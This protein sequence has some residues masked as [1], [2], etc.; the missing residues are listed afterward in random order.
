MGI[1]M[2]RFVNT[3]PGENQLKDNEYIS[4]MLHPNAVKKVLIAGNSI[5]R[6]NP[7]PDIGWYGDWGMAAS[8]A[9]KDYV[10]ILRRELTE[11]FGAVSMCV[12][13]AAEWEV[14][15]C[16][17][18]EEKLTE[19]Y[20]PALEFGADLIIIRLGENVNMEKTNVTE[21]TESLQKLAAFLSGNRENVQVIMTGLFWN[22]PVPEE[23]VKSA[24]AEKS[25]H[26][27]PIFDLGM[28]VKMTASG[29]FEHSGVAG[30]PGDLGMEHIAGRVMQTI[31]QIYRKG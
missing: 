6:H 11:Y 31:K 16:Q 12:V 24:A 27:I 20:M 7:K 3:V 14:T 29:L 1:S 28:D 13:Q 19:K 18:K 22:S 5:T 4:Y 9:D 15:D 25:Y 8:G 21:L 17:Y 23:A 2:E 26:Y 10:H 30:H